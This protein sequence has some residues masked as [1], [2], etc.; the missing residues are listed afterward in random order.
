M[1]IEIIEDIHVWFEQI[2]V[3]YL[4]AYTNVQHIC[5]CIYIFIAKGLDFSL[6]FS[7]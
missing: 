1:E 7:T 4:G 6:Q 2:I 5:I 3:R